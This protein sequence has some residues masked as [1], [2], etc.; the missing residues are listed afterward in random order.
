MII[1]ITEG[2]DNKA[3]TTR[4]ELIDFVFNGDKKIPS[5]PNI[6]GNNCIAMMVFN[7]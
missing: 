7:N 6:T 2:Q 4:Q 1:V 3:N 5:R